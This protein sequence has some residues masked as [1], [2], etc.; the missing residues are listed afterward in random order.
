M[1]WIARL[2]SALYN[3]CMAKNLTDKLNT[4]IRSRVQGA[5]DDLNPRRRDQPLKPGKN[6]DREVAALRQRINQALDDEDRMTAEIGALQGQVAD[7]DQQAD[8][9]LSRGDEAAA[10]H[11]VRQMQLVQQHQTMLEADLAQHRY[12]TSELISRVNELEARAAE[13]RQPSKGAV[14]PEDPDEESLSARISQARSAAAPQPRAAKPD[15]PAQVDEQ[16]IED[17]LARRRARLSQ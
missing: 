15:A 5:I 4:L 2:P 13:A 3:K 14:K 10:R 8:H 11:A 12:A 7:W 16:M 6:I 9:A 1:G 17:D